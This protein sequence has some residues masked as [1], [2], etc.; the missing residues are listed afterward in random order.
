MKMNGNS[1]L[2]PSEDSVLAQNALRSIEQV[3]E[4]Y[5]TKNLA[6][7]A[8]LTDSGLLSSLEKEL[9]FDRAGLSFS[10]PRVIT[11]SS[12]HVNI[13]VNWQGTWER[14]D[15]TKKNRGSSSFV[16]LKNSMRLVEI[17]GDNPFA[18]PA[19]NMQ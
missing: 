19:G 5:E 13:T 3:K 9:N 12:S 8:D 4:A 7:V 11:I 17:E 10:T 2:Q 1:W 18:V 6:S 14:G 16:F 15:V